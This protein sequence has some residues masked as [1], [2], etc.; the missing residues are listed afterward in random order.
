MDNGIIASGWTKAVLEDSTDSERLWVYMGNKE[1]EQKT[2]AQAGKKEAAI[3]E[4]ANWIEQQIEHV[5]H[6]LGKADRQA[7]RRLA[8][9]KCKEIT[10]YEFVYRGKLLAEARSYFSRAEQRWKFELMQVD[11]EYYAAVKEYFTRIK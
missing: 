6:A 1:G 4:T 10:E 2:V 3:K 9:R 7:E 8:I 5:W 11:Q